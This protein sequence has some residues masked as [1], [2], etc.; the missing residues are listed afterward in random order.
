MN[1]EIV[2]LYPCLMSVCHTRYSNLYYT[3]TV[4]IRV[5][6]RKVLVPPSLTYIS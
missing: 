3:P 2:T 6:M 4:D 1:T 5:Q